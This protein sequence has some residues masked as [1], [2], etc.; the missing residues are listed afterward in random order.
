[1][2]EE[3]ANAICQLT[4]E[5]Q[6]VVVASDSRCG[7]WKHE[8]INEHVYVIRRLCSLYFIY[9]PLDVNNKCNVHK[10]D[11]KDLQNYSIFYL[12]FLWKHS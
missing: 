12:L 6:T 5:Q 8:R 11:T 2:V 9:I 1:M 10:D 7:L 4:H 3:G